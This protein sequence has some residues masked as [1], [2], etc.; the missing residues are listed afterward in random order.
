MV[1]ATRLDVARQAIQPEVGASSYT[2]TSQTIDGRPGG[3]NVALNAVVLQMPGVVQDSFGQLHV[4]GDHANL[5]YRLNGVI[6]PEGLSAFGQTLS[7]RLAQ[8]VE[9]L[10]GALPAEY[11]LRTAGIVNITTKS[12]FNN[13]G[14]VSMYGGSHGTLEPSAEYGGSS[15]ANSYFLSGSY[16]RNDLGVESPD[17]SANPLHDRTRQY[18]LFGYFDHIFNEADRVS[19]LAGTSNQR[20]QIPDVPGLNAATDGSG[21]KI[22]GQSS[23]A[24][25]NLNQNQTEITDFA[26]A[27]WLHDAGRFTG[28]VS[29]FARYSKLQYLPDV[30]GELLFNEIAQAADKTDVAVGLQAEGVY[31]LTDAHTL[32]GGVIA[33]QDRA[34][35]D[36]TSQVLATPE[37]P[38]PVNNIP[39]TI[40]DNTIQTSH[41]YSVYAQDE[42]KLTA[43]FTINYGLRFDQLDSYRSENQFSPRVNFVWTATDSTSLFGGYARYFTPPP[44]ELVA[45]TTVNKFIRTAAEPAELADDTPRAE[46]DN[47]FD[48]GIKQKLTPALVVGVDAYYRAARNLLDEGQFGAPIILTPFNYAIGRIRGVEFSATYEQGPLSAYANF[49]ISKAVGK[50]INSS[51]FNFDPV[52]ELP[53]IAGHVIYLDHDQTY[54]GSAGASYRFGQTRASVD[55][56]YGS[57]LRADDPAGIVPNGGKLPGYATVNLGLSQSLSAGVGRPLTLRFD[58]INAFDKQYLIRDG[59]GVG[60]GAPQWGARRGFFGGLTVPFG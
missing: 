50:D 19:L 45:N 52:T 58:V 57:G 12:G 1:T 43:R 54:T 34:K 41:V 21:L 56:L 31:R 7:P 26:A 10:T 8:S 2:L 13:G 38:F 6:L 28:Q 37:N 32:R 51:Q 59:S 53:Y 33:Q 14:E 49:S 23:F 27:S 42:W 30:E 46:R 48:L 29:V 9:L 17:G 5:Q 16:N 60:V 40:I 55:L 11:G 22:N 35:S 44:F 25:E 15:G 3:D 24:S 4:R 47:Y 36:T 18:Q 39:L 20:F